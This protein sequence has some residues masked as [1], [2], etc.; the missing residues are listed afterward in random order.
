[1][2]T[3]GDDVRRRFRW[4]WEREELEEQQTG[5]GMMVRAV[6]GALS[7]HSLPAPAIQASRAGA[8]LPA[9]CPM[10]QRV[11]VGSAS[12][13]G[14]RPVV[15]R[16]CLKVRVTDR[17]R[18]EYES[19]VEVGLRTVCPEIVAATSGSRRYDCVPA[20]TKAPATTTATRLTAT[21][22]TSRRC[23]RLGGVGRSRRGA[24]GSRGSDGRALFRS[25]DGDGSQIVS[26]RL[27]FPQ[28]RRYLWAEE[29]R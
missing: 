17:N 4:W 10:P 11:H 22:L 1:M 6:R 13:T 12:E 3:T 2:F 19:L 27:F 7:R 23:R 26:C 5:R 25:V 28:K 15:G 24:A 9:V 21:R 16:G 8:G 18:A 14:Y 20:E 29:E